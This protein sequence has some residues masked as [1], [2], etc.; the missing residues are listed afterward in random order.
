MWISKKVKGYNCNKATKEY[1]IWTIG[2]VFSYL[3][4][5]INIYHTYFLV[6]LMKLLKN[7]ICIP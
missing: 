5:I 6:P 7:N 3:E 2:L 1:D 4:G